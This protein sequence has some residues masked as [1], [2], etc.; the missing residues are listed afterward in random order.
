MNVEE[1][2]RIVADQKDLMEEKMLANYV[3]RD[4]R[5]DISRYF[6]IPNVLAILGVRRSGKSTLS[7]LFMKKL[8]V[9]FVY[10]NFDDES[11]YGISSKDLRSLEQAVYEVYG[12]DV[13][14]FVLDEIH[15]VKGWELFVSRLR[16]TKRIIVTGS[17]SKMLSGELATAL[18]GRHSD[19][20]LFPFSFREYLRFKGE[21]EEL[22]LS[23]RRIAE[24]KR[25]LDKYL[26]EGGFPEALV[27]GKDQIDIIYNDIL[28]KDI[29]FRYKVKEMGKFKDFAK[30]LVL[31]YSTEVSLSRIANTISIDKKT[32]DQWAYGLE[33]AYLVYFLPRY[34]E[35]PRER[36]TFSKKVYLVDPGIISRIAIKAKDKGRLIENVVFLKLA[37]DNQLRGLYYIK[38]NNFE[39]DFYDEVNSR[40]VQVTYSSDKVEEREING[41]LKADELVKAKERIIVTYDVEGVEEVNGKE[42]KMIPLYKFLLLE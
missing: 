2:K 17:N 27:I 16:E 10:L 15:N 1:A 20:V 41:L 8:K 32:V 12:S 5:S 7:L 24:V 9:K 25:E 37:R 38:G 35:R 42:V 13:N 31:Y 33:N 39:V 6:S 23:T 19:L 40:L 26:E 36:L 34:G 18:T 3:E 30:S 29:I 14:Y 4:I 21:G 11:L 28:F 22:P